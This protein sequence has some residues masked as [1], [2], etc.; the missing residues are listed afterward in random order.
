MNLLQR[1]DV[2]CLQQGIF[3]MQTKAE[4]VLAVIFASSRLPEA[5]PGPRAPLAY[6]LGQEGKKKNHG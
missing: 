5:T 2:H 6:D 1:V 3:K 4:P